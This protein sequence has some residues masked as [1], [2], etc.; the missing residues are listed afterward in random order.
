V[1]ASE[2][3]LSQSSIWDLDSDLDSDL[4][5]DWLRTWF[6]EL[7]HTPVCFGCGYFVIAICTNIFIHHILGS[8]TWLRAVVSCCH[9]VGICW[10]VCKEA[11]EWQEGLDRSRLKK[12]LFDRWCWYPEECDDSLLEFCSLDSIVFCHLLVVLQ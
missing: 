12:N 5:L 8:G 7:G 10:L 4:V 2:S 11:F 6:L 1:F 3:C 9:F